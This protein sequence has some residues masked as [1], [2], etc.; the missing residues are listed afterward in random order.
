MSS[1]KT[2]QEKYLVLAVDAATVLH[3][4]QDLEHFLSHLK[5]MDKVARRYLKSDWKKI[6][7]TNPLD[8]F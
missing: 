4:I 1:R 2:E 8:E 6:Q 5:T 3:L 7:G